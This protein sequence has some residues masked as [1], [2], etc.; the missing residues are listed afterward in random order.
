MTIFDHNPLPSK[1]VFV[2]FEKIPK[3]CL[4]FIPLVIFTRYFPN[5]STVSNLR[6]ARL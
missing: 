3:A 1:L 4:Q 2:V 5:L 6:L